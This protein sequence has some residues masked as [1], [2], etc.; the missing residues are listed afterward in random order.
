MGSPRDFEAML[1]L[2]SQSSIKPLVWK[3]FEAE[4]VA[5]AFEALA[6]H[7]QLGKVVVKIPH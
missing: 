1:K 7:A 5:D 4:A 6:T 3:E 2:V